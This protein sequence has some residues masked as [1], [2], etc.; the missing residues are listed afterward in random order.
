MESTGVSYVTST[1]D[2]SLKQRMRSIAGVNDTSW[3]AAPLQQILVFDPL[4]R[5]TMSDLLNHQWFAVSPDLAIPS[6]SISE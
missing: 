1:R 6:G 3:L 5:T 4:R 2:A